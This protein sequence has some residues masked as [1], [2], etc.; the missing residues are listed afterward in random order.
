MFLGQNRKGIEAAGFSI[1]IAIAILLLSAGVIF[2]AIKYTAS[3]FDEKSQVEWCRTLNEIKSGLREKTSGALTSGQSICATINK[4]TDEKLFVPTS[5]YK[6]DKE[7]AELEI[8]DMIKNCWYMW[9][10]GSKQNMLRG[11]PFSDSC[12]TCYT[13]KIKDKA[14]DVT[15][16]SIFNSMDS[17]YYVKDMS[18]KCAPGGGGYWR[19][20]CN[21]DEKA[22]TPKTHQI[23]SDLK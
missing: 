15:S 19:Q 16:T 3:K 10:E 5:S 4:H 11:Y 2:A 7:G 9:L 6:Q 20:K 23:N 12:F 18:D 21:S 17:P 14:K 8:R 22:V 1:I 13:F